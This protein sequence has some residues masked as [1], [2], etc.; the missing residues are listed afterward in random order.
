[1]CHRMCCSKQRDN[2]GTSEWV[3]AYHG[4]NV[5]VLYQIMAST[6]LQKR[7][8]GIQSNAR[9][10][11]NRRVVYG[12]YCHRHGTIEKAGSYIMCTPSKF[13]S[14]GVLLELKVRRRKIVSCGD[15]WCLE[16]PGNVQVVAVWFHVLPHYEVARQANTMR[17]WFGRPWKPCYEMCSARQRGAHGGAFRARPSAAPGYQ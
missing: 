9:N 6:G 14:V 10:A 4:T 15:S 5:S 7:A 12:I 3:T 13:V 17:Y 1:M 2:E 16:D 11:L 8:L